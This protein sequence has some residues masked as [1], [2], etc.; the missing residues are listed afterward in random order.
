MTVN[1]MLLIKTLMTSNALQEDEPQTGLFKAIFID[2]PAGADHVNPH[3]TRVRDVPSL[4]EWSHPGVS[5]PGSGWIPTGLLIIGLP[6]AETL[7]HR[8]ALQMLG[9]DVFHPGRSVSEI[10]AA[11]QQPL[12]NPVGRSWITASLNLRA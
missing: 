1:D 6:P 3:F 7:S 10:R 11:A 9:Y 4:L 5:S 12:R 8:L 2:D